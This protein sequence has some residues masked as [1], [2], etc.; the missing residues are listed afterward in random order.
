MHGIIGFIRY[1]PVLCW[2]MTIGARYA[3]RCLIPSGESALLR[4]MTHLLK[5][6]NL[7]THG[8]KS[9]CGN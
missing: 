5:L 1:A 2:F 6:K 8:F 9:V 7:Q 4:S 3:C